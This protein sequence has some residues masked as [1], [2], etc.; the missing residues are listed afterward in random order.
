MRQKEPASVQGQL[1]ADV[2]EQVQ[3]L[4][5]FAL[6]DVPVHDQELTVKVA[7]LL[8]PF[9]LRVGGDALQQFG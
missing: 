4:P 5:L 7:H 1:G 6:S 3:V 2:P 9:L 8:R